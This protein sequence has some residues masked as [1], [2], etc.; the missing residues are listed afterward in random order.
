MFEFWGLITLS[1]LS[2]KDMSLMDLIKK[3]YQKSKVKSI[4][5]LI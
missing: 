3:I 5:H 4:I 2:I 1:I